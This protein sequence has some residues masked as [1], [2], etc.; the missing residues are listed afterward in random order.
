VTDTPTTEPATPP[1]RQQLLHEQLLA[2]LADLGLVTDNGLLP[3][4]S[5]RHGCVT[6]QPANEHALALAG[7]LAEQPDPTPAAARPLVDADGS[8]P[9]DG[10]LW[11]ASALGPD[12]DL[13]HRPRAAPGLDGLPAAL[14]G[15]TVQIITTTTPEPTAQLCGDCTRLPDPA[16]AELAA[17]NSALAEA[18]ARIEVLTAERETI[19]DAVIPVL[20]KWWEEKMRPLLPLMDDLSLLVPDTSADEAIYPTVEQAYAALITLTDTDEETVADC[21][22]CDWTT[23]GDHDPVE[24]YAVEHVTTHHTAAPNGD[25]QP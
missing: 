8:W 22:G 6:W 24:E 13:W 18:N 12:G 11:W 4:W 1:H 15:R 23:G 16:R 9:D 14:C 19:R 3:L 20:R 17:A 2:A 7:A 10:P 21:S 25:T 5:H